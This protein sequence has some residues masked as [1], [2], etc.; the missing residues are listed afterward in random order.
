M[1]NND[2]PSPGPS[3]GLRPLGANRPRRI[4]SRS[5]CPPCSNPAAHP[6]HILPNHSPA[7]NN[8]HQRYRFA[9][10]TPRRS[11]WQTRCNHRW[12][13]I[14]LIGLRHIFPRST[15]P[16]THSLLVLRTQHESEG[17]QLRTRRIHFPPAPTCSLEW[18]TC[19]WHHRSCLELCR[20]S[21]SDLGWLA[22]PSSWSWAVGGSQTVGSAVPHLGNGTRPCGT[23]RRHRNGRTL[24]SWPDRASSRS[25]HRGRRQFPQGRRNRPCG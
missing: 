8:R 12:W 17:Y 25:S 20:R 23:R 19:C 5:S 9:P 10:R 22:A 1:D 13:R 11:K 3:F 2:G 6:I 4:S 16:E 24:H 7:P 14:P 21:H 15:L 18:H